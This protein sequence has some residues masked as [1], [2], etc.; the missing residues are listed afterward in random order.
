MSEPRVLIL[1]GAGVLASAWSTVDSIVNQTGV[2]SEVVEFPMKGDNVGPQPTSIEEYSAWL[3]SMIERRDLTNV[4]LAGHSMGA[5]I[6]IDAA[7]HGSPRVSALVAMCPAEPMFVHP[8][9]LEAAEREPGEAVT[10]IAR[11]SYSPASRD[12]LENVIENNIAAASALDRGVL[13]TDLHACNNYRN[14]SNAAA[15]TTVPAII[16]LS[17]DDHMTPSASAKL[18]VDAFHNPELHVLEGVGHAINHEV[19]DDVAAIIVDASARVGL[20]TES[21]IRT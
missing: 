14:A 19:P 18:L 21:G 12:R 7:S 16:V 17:G 6:A 13:A 10:M 3:L 8:S 9:L 1:P 20:S 2:L 11:W 5:L 4:V 15:N